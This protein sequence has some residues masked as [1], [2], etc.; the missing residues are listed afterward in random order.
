VGFAPPQCFEQNLAA[1]FVAFR[2]HVH[3]TGI[4][5]EDRNPSVNCGRRDL[6]HRH[7]LEVPLEEEARG[8]NWDALSRAAANR[9]LYST[10]I[11]IEV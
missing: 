3:L 11:D 9:D 4:V 7:I 1:L 5:V 6:V 8:G 10:A 2:E